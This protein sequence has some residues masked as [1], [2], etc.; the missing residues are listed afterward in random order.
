MTSG[1]SV[2]RA[3]FAIGTGGEEEDIGLS[4]NPYPLNSDIQFKG[5]AM[6]LLISAKKLVTRRNVLQR[7]LKEARTSVMQAIMIRRI[8]TKIIRRHYKSKYIL[9]SKTENNPPL[10]YPSLKWVCY[11][12]Y[13]REVVTLSN[14]GSNL[15]T[16]Y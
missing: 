11:M 1:A 16:G 13:T 15:G 2:G 14:G 9:K 4:Q 3:R 6:P 8:A 7:F 12:S 10:A 5:A